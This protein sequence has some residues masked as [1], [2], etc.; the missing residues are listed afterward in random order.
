[1][2]KNNLQTL[3]VHCKEGCSFLLYK[4][5][6]KLHPVTK[7][8]AFLVEYFPCHLVKEARNVDGEIIVCSV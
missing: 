2:R 1:M 5:L 3:R 8:A 6:K 4:I 7:G